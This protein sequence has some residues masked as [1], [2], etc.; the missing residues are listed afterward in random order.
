MSDY[1]EGIEPELAERYNTTWL[2]P[3]DMGVLTITD[4][5]GYEGV[6]SFTASNGQSGTLDMV[7]GAGHDAVNMAGRA[8]TAMI[9]IPC[10]GGISHNEL[11]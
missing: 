8:P 3:S 4:V 6:V 11:E 2:C 1:G 7:S 9:F 10:A 5:T